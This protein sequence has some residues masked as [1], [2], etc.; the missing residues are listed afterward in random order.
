[1]K[2]FF[3]YLFL[4]ALLILPFKVS[5]TKVLSGEA[6]SKGSDGVIVGSLYMTYDQGEVV[7]GETIS[8]TAKNAVIESITGTS[9]W[10]KDDT[11]SILAN[12]G[13]SATL[14]VKPSAGTYTGTGEKI[15]IGEVRYKHDETYTGSDPCEVSISLPAGTGVT[16]QEKTTPQVN[17]G[18][19]IP[20][21]GIVAGIALI[22]TA[23]V[24]SRRSNKLYR[25]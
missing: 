6:S 15:K 16:I 7:T 21:V 12:D 20:Y 1:M 14:V 13:S 9:E 11:I 8:L 25:M 22:A 23:F 5:A 10:L 19:V 3:S 17:T 18:S 2:K 4:I 24:V